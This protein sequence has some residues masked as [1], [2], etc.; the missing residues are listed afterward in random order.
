MTQPDGSVLTWTGDIGEACGQ[1]WYHGHEPAGIYKDTGEPYSPAC[2]WL[3][4]N[5]SMKINLEKYLINDETSQGD[6]EKTDWCQFTQFSA[7][8]PQVQTRSPNLR[9]REYIVLGPGHSAIALCESNTSTGPGAVSFQEGVYRDM[10][11][12]KNY[13]LCSVQ[14]DAETCRDLKKRSVEKGRVYYHEKLHYW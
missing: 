2:T 14:P 8:E 7:N 1:E 13:P 11:T 5:L 12:H 3:D 10:A 4:G 6:V 9:R